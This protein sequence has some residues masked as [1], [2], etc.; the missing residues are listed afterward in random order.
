MRRKKSIDGYFVTITG[1]F[2]EDEDTVSGI[3]KQMSG[4]QPID[5]DH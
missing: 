4:K 5:D 1:T 3:K 2:V